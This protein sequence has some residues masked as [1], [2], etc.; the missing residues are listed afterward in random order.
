MSS[1]NS[2]IDSQPDAL[3]VISDSLESLEKPVVLALIDPIRYQEAVIGLLRYFMGKVPR[4]IYVSLNKPYAVL[5]KTFEKSGISVDSLFFVDAITNVPALQEETDHS[6]LGSTVDLSSLCIATS[7]AVNRFAED[8]FLV[9]DSLSTLLIYNE[10]KAVAKFAHLL[11]E[12]MRRWNTSGSLLTVEM[13]A[14]K[15]V[16]SQLA[17][18]C[19]KVVRI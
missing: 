19:D 10:S 15:D 17:P 2:K 1:H 4:G 7:K 14:E 8:K 13:N 5:A 11:T 9:L 6:C 16:V 3:T 18:F 12:K